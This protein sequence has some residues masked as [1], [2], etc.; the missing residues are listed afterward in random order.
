MFGKNNDL[1]QV[2]ME[3]LDK[4][5]E[6]KRKIDTKIAELEQS[7]RG[8]QAKITEQ[9]SIMVEYELSENEA[10]VDNCR[11]VIR[12]LRTS[13][14]ETEDWIAGYMR[15]LEINPSREKEIS[16]I[17]EVAA[18]INKE[19]LDRIPKI[20]TERNKL[21]QQVKELERRIEQVKQEYQEA[22]IDREVPVLTKI[23]PLIEP[24]LAKPGTAYYDTESFLRGWIQGQSSEEYFDTNLRY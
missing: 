18:K 10:E 1:N 9:T 11:R 14:A 21:D 7:S 20:Q 3:F 17:R 6:R 15:Q 4:E 19:R 2:V 12:E 8:I 24:R 23:L 16:R 22:N 5:R 13:L